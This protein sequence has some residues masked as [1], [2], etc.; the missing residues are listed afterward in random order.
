VSRKDVPTTSA[1]LP[2]A[3]ML[4][5]FVPALLYEQL[6]LCDVILMPS[7]EATPRTLAEGSATEKAE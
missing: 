1:F 6:S 7:A 3:L 2:T 4:A 5:P